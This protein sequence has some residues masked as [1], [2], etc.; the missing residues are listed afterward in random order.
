MGMAEWDIAP[1]TNKNG[2]FLKFKQSDSLSCLS[3]Y[4]SS[5]YSYGSDF[6][7]PVLITAWFAD[8]DIS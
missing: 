4:L 5:Y 2:N 8:A 6:T 3:C 1:A 7:N